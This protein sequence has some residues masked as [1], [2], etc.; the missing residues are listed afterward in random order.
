MYIPISTITKLKQ[1]GEKSVGVRHLSKY[2]I[3]TIPTTKLRV[4]LQ[5]DYSILTKLKDGE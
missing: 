2:N 3:K 5:G 1:E 4:F